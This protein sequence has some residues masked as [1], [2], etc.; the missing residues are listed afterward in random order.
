MSFT[1]EAFRAQLT[2]ISGILVSPF[3]HH[4]QFDPAPLKPIVDRAVAAGVHILTANGNTGEFYGLTTAEAERAVHA[5]GEVIA[6]RVPMLAGIGRSIGDA[7]ALTKASRAAGA[8]ALMVHQP[9]DPFVAPRGVVEYVKRVAESGQGLPVVIYLRNDGIGLD[10]I[11]DLCAI[12]GVVGVKWATPAPLR[13]A[14]AIR[15]ADPSIVWVGGLAE[16]WAPPFYAVGA[17]G[18]TSGLINVWPAHSMAIHTALE[19]GDYAKARAL[20]ATMESFEA[21]RAEEGN[22]TN[23]SVVKAALKLMGH[24]CG[25]ARPPG[26]WPLTARQHDELAKRLAEWGLTKA[27]AA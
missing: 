12:P 11:A 24:D 4:D 22:G 16:T 5:A 20:I 9:P 8:S 27:R 25:A 23:V 17:R 14:E 1:A 18:F 2:G 13:L 10:A 26:A 19:A 7:L 3:D 21:L 6:G 15:R